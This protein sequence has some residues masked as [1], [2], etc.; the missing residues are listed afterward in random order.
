MEIDDVC[1]RDERWVELSVND[2]FPSELGPIFRKAQSYAREQGIR[3]ME[4][5]IPVESKDE[6]E[7]PLK[8]LGF[9]DGLVE[10]WRPVPRDQKPIT[11]PLESVTILQNMTEPEKLQLILEQQALVHY[12]LEPNYYLAPTEINWSAILTELEEE[13]R[14][15]EG[16]QLVALTDQKVSGLLRGEV[17]HNVLHLWDAV[18]DQSV[19]SKGIGT[20]L[21]E[22]CL[23]IAHNKNIP[24]QL[25]TWKTQRSFHWYQKLGFS[26]TRQSYYQRS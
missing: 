24:L 8:A 15:P 2:S 12:E 7:Q 11:F 16:I 23:V 14:N 3:K 17:I 22:Q 26:V 5:T 19:R 10:L 25:E 20:A 18:V 9:Q 4:V 13:R 21:M 6:W 1:L